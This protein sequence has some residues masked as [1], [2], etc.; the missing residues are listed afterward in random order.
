MQMIETESSHA[1]LSQN[2]SRMELVS[3][4]QIL[5]RNENGDSAK[6]KDV[7]QTIDW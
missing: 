3:D 7:W 5:T 4:G 2:S 6:Y 1:K